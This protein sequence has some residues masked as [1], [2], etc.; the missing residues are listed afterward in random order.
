M[1]ALLVAVILIASLILGKIFFFNGKSTDSKEGGQGAKNSLPTAKG[2]GGDSKPIQ[3][4]T[5]SVSIDNSDKVI[6]SS[7]T[8]IAN[9]E[10]E[11]KSE[12]SGKI[13]ALYITEGA[14][15][16][17]G[18]LIAKIKD[19]DILAQLKKIEI[20]EKLANQI[21]QRQKKLLEINAISKEEYEISQNRVYTLNAD[22]E[23][24]KVQLSR[25]EIRAPF[26]GKLGLKNI[27][28][29][30]Y[31][32]PATIISTLIQFNPIKIDFA[33]PEKY[34]VDLQLGRNVDFQ[35]DGNTDKF[36]AR[37]IAIEPKV[38]ESLRTLKVRAVTQNP[39]SKLYPGMFLKILLNLGSQQS[40]M[41]PTETVIPVIDGKKVFVKRN[42][43]AEEIKIVTG[44]RNE[45]K[46]QVISGLSVGDSLIT[47][48]LMTLKAGT[49][50]FSKK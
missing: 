13:T 8:T 29:G 27:S 26:S 48:G 49:P 18:K 39:N 3:V 16:P 25:T 35:I 40:I 23:I 14:V 36:T 31:V 34:I 50:V 45:S 24:L 12:I 9:E 38:D 22:K 44:L 5:I 47:S 11:L 1:R 2:M 15:V 21:E 19:D 28:I 20:E 30:A 46:L 32:T 6:F 33:V 42:G 10:V 37:I 41:I 17:A 7:G 4:N 43:V